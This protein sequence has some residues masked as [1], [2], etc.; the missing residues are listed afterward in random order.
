[1]QEDNDEAVLACIHHYMLSDASSVRHF[2]YQLLREYVQ[3]LSAQPELGYL[4]Y[5]AYQQWRLL[6]YDAQALKSALA[7]RLNKAKPP[8]LRQ[9]HLA[10]VENHAFFVQGN[11]PTD[12][13]VRLTRA[14]GKQ[15]LTLYSLLFTVFA[16][17][18][19]TFSGQNSD[20]P[21][22]LRVMN[23][24][25]AFSQ[26]IGP[27]IS[28]MPV[29]TTLQPDHSVLSNVKSIQH[30]ILQLQQH[31]WLNI[32]H[33][34]AEIHGGAARVNELVQIL[35]TFYNFEND[36]I[37]VPGVYY[38]LDPYPD[39]SEKFGMSLFATQREN[40]I[41]FTLSPAENRYEAADVQNILDVLVHAL[42][43]F[44]RQSLDIPLE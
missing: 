34:A 39:L 12:V 15:G 40:Q 2:A 20:F 28:T 35:F 10:G 5:S 16:H 23:R 1:M 21:I 25:E 4:D 41:S 31:P 3:P 13:V 8:A 44:N 42:T 6:Q 36:D 14:C 11:L 27:F 19:R 22:W 29:I 9:R 18:L 37:A 7:A 38:R 26:A 33:L 43:Q 24:P 17:V 32:G 30:D